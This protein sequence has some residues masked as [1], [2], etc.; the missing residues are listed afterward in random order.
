MLELVARS[1][2]VDQDVAPFE[3]LAQASPGFA[4][5]QSRLRGLRALI[6]V[7]PFEAL[8]WSILGQQINVAFAYRLKRTLVENFGEKL[9]YADA[10]YHLFPRVERLA[11]LEPEQLR[12][13]QFSSQKSRYIIDLARMIIDGSLDLEA[14]RNLHPTKLAPS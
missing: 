6:M 1:F 11:A 2:R 3:S 12:P 9:E 4:A 10:T 7:S 8:V 14:L 5:L 13:L